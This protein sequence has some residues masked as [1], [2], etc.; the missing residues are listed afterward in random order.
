MTWLWIAIVVV[1]LVLIGLWLA[2]SYNGL[3]RQRNLVQESWRQIDVELQRRHDLIPN[4]VQTVQGYAS[5]EQGTLAAVIEARNQA[6]AVRQSPNTGAAEQGQAESFL[7]AT[8]GRLFALAEAYPNLK[9]NESFL[10]LQGQLAETEDRVAAGRRYYNANVRTMNN[11]VQSFPSNILA[12]MFGFKQAEY[13]EVEQQEARVA[14]QVSF[15][16]VGGTPA[17][18]T[19]FPTQPAAPQQGAPAPLPYQQQPPAPGGGATPP[20][21][22]PAPPPGPPQ[23]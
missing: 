21:Q 16:G 17:A 12:G 7:G 2:F 6:V 15:P 10:A 5:H 8:L 18:A 3:V 11:K 1:L 19:T 23:P 4:L 9:A 13:F 14:P 22:P 20:Y